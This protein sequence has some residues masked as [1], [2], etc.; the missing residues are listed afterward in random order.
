MEQHT[1]QSASQARGHAPVSV[2]RQ[3]QLRPT[4]R[5]S[6]TTLP[7]ASSHSHPLA[8]PHAMSAQGSHSARGWGEELTS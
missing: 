1:S 7:R 6:S 3:W 4:W 8:A 5:P 2:T